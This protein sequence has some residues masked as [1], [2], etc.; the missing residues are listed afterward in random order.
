VR[1][2]IRGFMITVFDAKKMPGPAGLSG[3]LVAPI[4][5]DGTPR[6]VGPFAMV[7][8]AALPHSPPGALPVDVDVR[9]HP[10]RVG[11]AKR[12]GV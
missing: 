5:T 10:Q 4:D 2:F 3:A 11:Q 1:D 8:H 6:T 9:P 7:A 12:F